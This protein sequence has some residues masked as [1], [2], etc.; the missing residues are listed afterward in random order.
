MCDKIARVSPG[1]LY[2]IGRVLNA[3]YIDYSYVAAIKDIGADFDLFENETTDRL[4][5]MGLLEGDFSGRVVPKE[6]TVSLFTPVFFGT[7]E[8]TLDICTIAEP[9]R[10]DTFKFHFFDD[11]ITKVTG[12]D[13]EIL[14]LENIEKD[15]LV[16]MI[17]SLLIRNLKTEDTPDEEE[18]SKEKVTRFVVAKSNHVSVNSMVATF[19][20]VNGRM[21][22]EDA[23]GNVFC[24]K[25]DEFK[26]EIARILMGVM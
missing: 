4:V 1:E 7:I 22:K 20:E 18:F 24:L 10:I 16:K 17:D 25:T 14:Q 13:G 5:A 9:T 6:D 23:A 19:M 2:V 26:E 8:T 12:I 11:Q 3:K 15:A 21:Y